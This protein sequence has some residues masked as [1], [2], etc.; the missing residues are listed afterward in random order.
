MP[1]KANAV[2][3]ANREKSIVSTLFYCD[4][5]LTASKVSTRRN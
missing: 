4:Q 5:R 1:F 3:E 2:L